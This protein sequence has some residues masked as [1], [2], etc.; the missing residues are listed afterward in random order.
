I[1]G[2]CTTD[3]EEITSEEESIKGADRLWHQFRFSVGAPD[4]EA[5][6][7]DAVKQAQQ[8]DPNTREYPSLFAWHGSSLR[9]RNWHS[10]IRHGLW[11]KHV[12]NG[13]AFGDGK[14]LDF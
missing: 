2:S 7:R 3:L 13:R 14:Y 9:L 6:F 1:I 12:V 4:T 8:E 5:R 11:F 10:I